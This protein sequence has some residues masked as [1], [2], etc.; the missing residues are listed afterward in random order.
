LVLLLPESLKGFLES[1]DRKSDMVAVGAEV[2]VGVVA[3]GAWRRGGGRGEVAG[4]ALG[5]AAR[6]GGG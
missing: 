4:G 3:G 1:G 2:V 5:A 6:A